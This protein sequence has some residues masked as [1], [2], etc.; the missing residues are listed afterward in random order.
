MHTLS[1]SIYLHGSDANL[2]VCNSFVSTHLYRFHLI[3]PGDKM[4][5]DVAYLTGFMNRTS[6]NFSQTSII[7]VPNG[8]SFSTKIPIPA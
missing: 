5:L 1:I 6:S 7:L 3:S 2:H 4:K 8:S